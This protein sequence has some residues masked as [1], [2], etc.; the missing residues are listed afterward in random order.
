MMPNK[1][2]RRTVNSPVQL[3]LV[4]AWRHVW[5]AGRARSALL[6]AAERRSVIRRTSAAPLYGSAGP[7]SLPTRSAT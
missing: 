1:V 7:G 6:L 5:A 4:A 2:L 3:T